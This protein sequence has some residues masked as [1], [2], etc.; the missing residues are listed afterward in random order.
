MWL[1]LQSLGALE[2]YIK[3][4]LRILFDTT[5]NRNYSVLPVFPTSQPSLLSLFDCLYI[6]SFFFLSPHLFVSHILL[7]L[8]CCFPGLSV[9]SLSLWHYLLPLRVYSVFLSS[10]FSASVPF[11]FI[12]SPLTNIPSTS[13]SAPVIPPLLDPRTSSAV[14]PF[15]PSFPPSPLM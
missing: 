7:H 9:L 8:P 13:R 10:C 1:Y 3:M 6:I 12:Y 15:L 14:N 4:S 5:L 2:R 11:S